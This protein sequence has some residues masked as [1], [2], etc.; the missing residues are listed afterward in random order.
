MIFISLMEKFNF[1]LVLV[2]KFPG[3][4]NLHF[5]I[6]QFINFPGKTQVWLNSYPE[7]IKKIIIKILGY[8][9]GV[10]L[11]TTQI[12]EMNFLIQ[13]ASL[14]A[15]EAA[16]YSTTVVESVIVSYLELLQLITPSFNVNT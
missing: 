1:I 5:T 14:S 13:T 8:F 2:P 9:W 6:C 12:Y 4:L 15:L 16:M 11:V 3:S 10:T 7:Y